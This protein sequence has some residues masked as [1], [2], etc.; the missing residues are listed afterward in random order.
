MST[1]SDRRDWR[2][3]CRPMLLSMSVMLA[4][5]ACGG[6]GSTP[7]S[8]GSEAL[9]ASPTASPA[10]ASPTATPSSMPGLGAFTATGSMAVSRVG[11]IAVAL[12]DGRVLVATGAD[13]PR[14]ELYDPRAGTF[15][16]T[17]SMTKVRTGGAAATRLKN[18]QVLIAG[19]NDNS[20]DQK[21][22][23]SAELYDPNTG[24]FT[25]TGSMVS[26]RSGHTATLLGNGQVLIVGGYDASGGCAA[27]AELYN[28]STA[29]FGPT[30]AMNHVRAHHTATLLNNG[31]VLIVGGYC[32][33]PAGDKTPSSAELYDP[34]TGRF[35]ETGSMSAGRFS[36]FAA[37]P[38]PDGR[39]LVAGGSAS[40]IEEKELA[41]AELYD[42]ASRQFTPTGSMTA[43]RVGHTAT[44]L[45]DGR[46]LV[47]GGDVRSAELFDPTKGSFALIGSMVVW[48]A[49]HSATLLG[50]GSVLFA[51]GADM[52]N[53][54]TA[55][56]YRPQGPPER[57]APEG[58]SPSSPDRF[59]AKLPLDQ[60]RE[61]P[62]C[63]GGSRLG[64][65]SP[66]ESGGH[67]RPQGTTRTSPAREME[68]LAD[69]G[70]SVRRCS[71]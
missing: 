9:T 36:G 25:A 3:D 55:E 70:G 50:D 58:A 45:G 62:F 32:G 10:T 19:G 14:A 28:P 48:R 16:S 39:V 4:V 23:A 43:A 71:G 64:S 20:L 11:Q 65:R 15:G 5:V 18:G 49:F 60:A 42:P 26:A 31:Q 17:G 52:P 46:V 68:R 8:S 35:A 33:G 38:L 67:R 24:Q 56:L 6:S 34:S 51:G 47:A 27:A 22:L 13:D 59:S 61:G 66:T 2:R 63:L 54:A 44:L 21:P 1:H 12:E 69:S 7:T 30:G 40:A 41:S 37:T 29:K 57:D 53:G